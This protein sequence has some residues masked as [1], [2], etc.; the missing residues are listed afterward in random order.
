AGGADE[1]DGSLFDTELWKI[2]DGDRHLYDAWFYMSDSGTFFRAGT[3]EDV[4]MVI[5]C[6]LECED[7]ELRARLGPAMVEARLLPAGDASYAGFAAALELQ[8][9][10]GTGEGEEPEPAAKKPAAAT[11]KP[12]AKKPA[13]KKAAAKKAAAKKAAPQKPAAKKAP[14]K[15]AAPKRAAKKPAKR[16]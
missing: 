7:T 6:G 4:A 8:L 12:A 14:V 16:R 11:K 2:V 1:G 5:Q 13:A 3:T 15:K 9:T 10:E